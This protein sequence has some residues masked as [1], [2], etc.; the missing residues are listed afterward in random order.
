MLH[1]SACISMEGLFALGRSSDAS[2]ILRAICLYATSREG[3][4]VVNGYALRGA[5]DEFPLVDPAMADGTVR[6]IEEQVD[7]VLVRI[8]LVMVRAEPGVRAWPNLSRCAIAVVAARLGLLAQALDMS[9]RHLEGRQSFG[10]K[11]MHHQLIKTRF[12]HANTLIVR[13]LEEIGLAEGC[14]ELQDL[15]RMHSAISD[16]FA[17]VSKLMGGHGY[18]ISGINSLEYLSSLMAS[19]YARPIAARFAGSTYRD[20]TIHLVQIGDAL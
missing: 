15:E 12:A 1:V 9:F 14:D 3:Y 13:L 5:D 10:Q 20:R 2:T 19:I 16:E 7:I 11:T 18:L 4:L 6:L 17:Q 8:G